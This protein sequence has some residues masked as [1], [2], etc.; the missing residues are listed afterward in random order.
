MVAYWGLVVG[1]EEQRQAVE[2]A[3]GEHMMVHNR[4]CDAT[5]LIAATGAAAWDKVLRTRQAPW[6]LTWHSCSSV[7]PD[8]DAA[9]HLHVSNSHT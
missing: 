9:C 7:L 6:Y 1:T 2:L 4:V 3:I 5:V 8:V